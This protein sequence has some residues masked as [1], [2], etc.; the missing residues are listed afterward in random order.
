LF[1][2]ST[3][4]SS[5]GTT[6]REEGLEIFVGQ[7]RFHPIRILSAGRPTPNRCE[8]RGYDP[9]S[10]PSR[11]SRH[12]DPTRLVVAKGVLQQGA[13]DELV[14][15]LPQ[16]QFQTLVEILGNEYLFVDLGNGSCTTDCAIENANGPPLIPNV[17]IKFN[18][19]VVRAGIN[20]KFGS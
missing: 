8:P 15:Q 4:G 19:S 3:I 9:P 2:S 1:F 20:Y 12:D 11:S 18:E 13:G 17:A 5:D 6:R 10:R 14:E 7:D 16:R